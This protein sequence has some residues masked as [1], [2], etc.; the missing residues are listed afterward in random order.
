MKRYIIFSFAVLAGLTLHIRAQEIA[1]ENMPVMAD[2][3]MGNGAVSVPEPVPAAADMFPDGAAGAE[4]E[5]L[6]LVFVNG[7][8]NLARAA[9]ADVNEMEMV[10]ST[11][12]VAVTVELGLLDDRGT[13]TRLY[14]A[15]DIT[16]AASDLHMVF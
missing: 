15:K 8:N 5:W 1:F 13:S 2:G 4:R 10:G 3:I 11:D 14:V 7:R 6:V 16:A 9:I 12:K